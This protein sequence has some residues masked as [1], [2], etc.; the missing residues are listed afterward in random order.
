M[1]LLVAVGC[2]LG[3]PIKLSQYAL[4]PCTRGSSSDLR[5]NQKLFVVLQLCTNEQLERPANKSLKL[6]SVL[7]TRSVERED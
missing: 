7:R 4:T 3:G 2:F 1:L 5:A 6:R